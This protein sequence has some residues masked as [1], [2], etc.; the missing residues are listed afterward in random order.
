MTAKQKKRVQKI[1]QLA[2]NKV[3]EAELMK[4]YIAFYTKDLPEGEEKAKVGLEMLSRQKVIDDTN[5]FIKDF[6]AYVETL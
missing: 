1:L 4:G 6:T 2:E 5:K 3:I